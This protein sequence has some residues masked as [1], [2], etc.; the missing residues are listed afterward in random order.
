[1]CANL[2]LCR[3]QA[4]DCQLVR[5]RDCRSVKNGLAP[6]RDVRPDARVRH[7]EQQLRGELPLD[8]WRPDRQVVP[9]RELMAAPWV[10]RDE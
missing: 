4:H 1:M 8:V 6:L 5:G 2:V 9:Q 3:G 10:R 7:Q